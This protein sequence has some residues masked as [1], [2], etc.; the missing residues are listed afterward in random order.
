MID[1]PVLFSLAKYNA[2]ANRMLL[3]TAAN[4]STTQL[5]YTPSP[6]R[7][8]ALQ[9]IQHMLATEVHYLALCQERSFKFIREEYSTIENLRALS[10]QLGANFQQLVE[11]SSEEDLQRVLDVKIGDYNFRFPIWQLLIQAV[12]HSSEHR[13]DLSILL[14]SIGYPVPSSDLIVH[15]AQESGQ[16][17]PWELTRHGSACKIKHTCQ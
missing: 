4:M 9:L 10:G 14:S 7:N 5:E 6:S 8:S 13:G 17:W 3:E 12:M 11:A 2:Y 16:S 1:Q 15:F